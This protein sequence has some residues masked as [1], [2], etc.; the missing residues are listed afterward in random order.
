MMCVSGLQG[1]EDWTD[2]FSSFKS[3]VVVLHRSVLHSLRY[4]HTSVCIKKFQVENGEGL[5]GKDAFKLIQRIKTC[6]TKLCHT[7][8]ALSQHRVIS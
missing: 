4:K 7:F 2:S 6:Q 1:L 8:K 3:A 5:M